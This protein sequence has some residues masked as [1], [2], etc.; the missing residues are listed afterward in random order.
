[1]LLPS[2]TVTFL[3]TDIEG[4]TKLWEECPE[5]MRQALARHDALAASIIEQHEG[6]LVKSR[7]E[8]D[9]LFCVFARATDA[10]AAACALQQAFVSEPWPAEAPLRV[11]MALH[12]G[13]ADLREGDYYGS[14][15][16]RCAR[17]RAIGHGGQVLLSQAA[18]DLLPPDAPLMDKGSH[19]LKDLQQPEHV[20]Q[21]AAPDLPSEFPPLRSLRN[22]NL[23]VQTTSFIG[24]EQEMAQLKRLFSST[25]LLTLTGIGG[26]GKTRLALQAA[27]DLLED[28]PDGAWLVELA[29][30]SEGSPVPQSVASALGL[31]EEPGRSLTQTLIDYLQSR[32]LLLILDNCE[33]LVAA[34]ASLAETLLRS[35]PNVKLLATSREALNVPGETTYRVPSLLPPDPERLPSEEKDLAAALMDYDAVRLFV[36]RACSHRSEFALTRQNGPA[37]AEICHQLDGIP[38]AIEL[39]AA[40]IRAMAVE[41]I[42]ERLDDRFRLLTSGSRTVLPRQQ[43]LRALIDWSYDLLSEQEQLLLSRLS[44]FAGGWT[45]EAAEAVCAGQGIEDWEVLDLLTGLVDKSLVL[46]EEREGQARYRLLETVRQYAAE[47]SEAGGEQEALHRRHLD[48]FSQYLE[49]KKPN[50]AERSEREYANLR[51]ALEWCRTQ[52]DSAGAGLR[53]AGWLSHFWGMRGRYSE[54]RQWLETMLQKSSRTP[55]ALRAGALFQVGYMAGAQGDY[56]AARAFY[57]ESL[58]IYR[59]LDDQQEIASVLN[60]LAL[61]AHF[62]GDYST[63][64]SLYE[65][66]RIINEALGNTSGVAYVLNNQGLAAYHQGDYAAARAC[67][68]K[69]L[70]TFQE[71]GNKY[72]MVLTLDNLGLLSTAEGDY[73]SARALQRQGL[74]IARDLGYKG[75]VV[76]FLE[77]FAKLAAAQQ[78]GERA[79]VLWAVAA[80]QREAMSSPLWPCVLAEYER[81]L[82]DVREALGEE[83]FAAAWAEGQAMTLEQAMEYALEEVGTGRHSQPC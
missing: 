83:A 48:Y 62:Q 19:R 21:L 72:G 71:M 8:G 27:A 33:H 3:F 78:Q 5:A 35:S 41:K 55:M 69:C 10:V 40:R 53:L 67:Y 4:S 61:L 50:L 32:S 70:P 45:L 12:T 13:E 46:Y 47:E 44:I 57:E 80:A 56:A 73:A 43:T 1:M 22:T 16:N 30:L 66:S 18:R 39:A 64:L 42:A 29:A 52:E 11:R 75:G 17:L 24:R 26:C 31:R 60:M 25:R 49:P 2:G 20:F 15:V 76:W 58:A 79:A 6:L 81:S 34:C 23:P 54:G 68:E 36:E 37:V 82:G 38:L 51:A 9:S 59:Q 28:Y 7:G 14:A 65:Q 74:E 63:A 77:G